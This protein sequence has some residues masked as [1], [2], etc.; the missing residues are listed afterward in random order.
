MADGNSALVQ[1]QADFAQAV[2]SLLVSARK[3][4]LTITLGEAERPGILADLYAKTGRGIRNSQHGDRLAIDLR[5]YVNGVYQAETPAYARLGAQ[6][7]VRDKRARW[8][9][10]F[11]KPDG[12]HFEFIDAQEV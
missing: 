1:Q 4:R 6:W 3:Q 10:D 11:P 7:K 12:N 2:A 9:G 8:G 5:L